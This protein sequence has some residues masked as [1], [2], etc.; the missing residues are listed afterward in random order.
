MMKSG[1]IVLVWLLIILTL[2]FWIRTVILDYLRGFWDSV[3]INTVCRSREKC[4]LI[5]EMLT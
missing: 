5:V 2:V 3:I 4:Y 1:Q